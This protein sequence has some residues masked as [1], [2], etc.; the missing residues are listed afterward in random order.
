MEGW[1]KYLEGNIS[2]QKERLSK[3]DNIRYAYCLA[4]SY[5]LPSKVQRK[6]LNALS[7]RITRQTIQLNISR[8]TRTSA[9][10]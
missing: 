6:R 5:G 1:Q 2:T 10:P 9:F 7:I 8:A 4:G 3:I